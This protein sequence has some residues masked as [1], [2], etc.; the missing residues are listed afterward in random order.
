MEIFITL[1]TLYFGSLL[2]WSIICLLTFSISFVFKVPVLM[3]GLSGIAS[4]VYGILQFIIYIYLLINIWGYGFLW[5][6]FMIFIGLSL[7]STLINLLQIPFVIIPAYF[8]VKLENLDNEEDVVR[9]EVIDNKG[10]IIDIIEDDTSINKRLV[11][12]YLGLYFILLLGILIFPVERQTTLWWEYITR[13]FFQSLSGTLFFGIIYGLY[14]KIKFKSVFTQDK[15]LF[16]IKLWRFLCIF[17]LIFLV[18]LLL[19]SLAT[20]TYY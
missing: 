3:K 6:I 1:L 19:F 16:F 12:Y 17:D 4:F 13:P 5:F 15:R 2:V 20:G 10:N 18:A 9:A 8:L 11:K 7:F 14:R